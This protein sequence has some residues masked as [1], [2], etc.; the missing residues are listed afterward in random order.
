MICRWT[1]TKTKITTTSRKLLCVW[2]G[3]PVAALTDT[4]PSHGKPDFPKPD[5]F[6]NLTSLNLTFPKL[7]NSIHLTFPKHD[8]PKPYNSQNLT[9]P[10]A[11]F[12]TPDFPNPEIP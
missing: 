7:N 11:D 12:H 10:T 1:K 6:L 2:S 8:F 4:L 9:F 5:N 3:D